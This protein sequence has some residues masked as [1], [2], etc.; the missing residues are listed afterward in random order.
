[1]K[2]FTPSRNMMF[3]SSQ[4]YQVKKKKKKKYIG[5]KWV[6]RKKFKADGSFDKYKARSMAKVFTQ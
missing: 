4:I 3:G 2:S 1:M 5:C 6:L